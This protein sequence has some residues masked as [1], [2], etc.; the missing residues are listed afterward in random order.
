V[1]GYALQ[2]GFGLA[3]GV[4]LSRGGFA[5]WHQV[6]GM[7]QL[8]TWDLAIAFATVLLLTGPLWRRLE[9]YAAIP[10]RRPIHPGSIPGGL[11]FGVGWAL[12]GACP[13]LALVQLGQGK[14]MAAMTLLGVVIGNYAYALTHER[15]FRWPPSSCADD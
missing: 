15:F 12:S 14:G 5:D 13:A 3:F 9:R 2:G 1:K 11:T 10:L 7:L 8:R 6:H 4:V